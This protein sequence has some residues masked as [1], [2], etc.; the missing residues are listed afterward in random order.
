MNK[1]ELINNF[2]VGDFYKL[3]TDELIYLLKHM[4]KDSLTKIVPATN[5]H[6]VPVYAPKKWEGKRILLVLLD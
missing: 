4:K 3:T 2:I 6:S 1:E 5:R